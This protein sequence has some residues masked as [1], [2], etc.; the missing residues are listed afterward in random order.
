MTT[1][2]FDNGLMAISGWGVL[3][4]AAAIG[5]LAVMVVLLVMVV[6]AARRRGEG[7]GWED[8]E[9]SAA[10]RGAQGTLPK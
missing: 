7:V 9:P 6:I 10:A 3:L 4:I 5:V 1:T 2:P 8:Q